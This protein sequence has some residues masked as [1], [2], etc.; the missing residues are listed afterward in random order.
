MMGGISAAHV[1]VAIVAAAKI[2]RTDPARVFEDGRLHARTRILAA[3]ATCA[4]L[5]QGKADAG[6][7]FKV[8]AQR[9]APSMLVK[10][11]I[12]TEQLLEIAEALEA[13]GLTAHDDARA[14]FL[15]PFEA[16]TRRTQ[17]AAAEAK[18]SRKPG[19]GKSGQDRPSPS[20]SAPDAA[21]A[22]AAKKRGRPPASGT[23]QAVGR[24]GGAARARARP[25][26]AGLRAIADLK[27]VTPDIARWSGYFLEA[28]W[29]LSTVADLFE[30]CPMALLDALDPVEAQ[31]QQVR[32]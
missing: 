32:A 12:T 22:P 10:E 8:Q 31:G 30:V 28:D 16:E 4:R 9:L 24:L 6:R 19:P 26:S 18:P 11:K 3:A 14:R 20:R 2:L 17:A 7:L 29:R 27:P 15:T 25:S 23:F 13:A 21:P 5:G 1:A